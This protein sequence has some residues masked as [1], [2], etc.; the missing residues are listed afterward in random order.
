[1]TQS[2]SAPDFVGGGIDNWSIRFWPV[3][4][5][6]HANEGSFVEHPSPVKPGIAHLRTFSFAQ[7]RDS[8]LLGNPYS[9]LQT[10][11]P[12]CKDLPILMRSDM[13][14]W[15]NKVQ[16]IRTEVQHWAL[17]FCLLSG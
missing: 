11:T 8:Q 14:D 13:K 3:A 2:I 15:W 9:A 10:V 5:G 6:K 12:K 7:T 4:R 17:V 16:N 1:M